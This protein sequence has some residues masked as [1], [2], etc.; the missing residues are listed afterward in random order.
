MDKFSQEPS[1]HS[2]PPNPHTKSKRF[3][4]RNG[5]RQNHRG[6][7]VA[8]EEYWDEMSDHHESYSPATT[9]RMIHSSCA[10]SGF[11]AKCSPIAT[12]AAPIIIL[13]RRRRFL[14][15]N[16]RITRRLVRAWSTHISLSFFLTSKSWQRG[17]HAFSF[18]RYSHRMID[19]FSIYG[20]LNV[21]LGTDIFSK[22]SLSYSFFGQAST[23]EKC[24]TNDHFSFSLRKQKSHS[25]NL[26][27]LL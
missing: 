8:D 16:P 13:H 14:T 19:H 20:L 2:H 7:S 6:R 12:I 27:V 18:S 10:R 4:G 23:A 26:A 5:R 15:T 21:Q 3:L 22:H 25:G 24:K 9:L 1:L 17:K 11:F